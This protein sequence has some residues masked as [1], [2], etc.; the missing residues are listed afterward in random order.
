M[1]TTISPQVA[2]VDFHHARYVGSSL[3]FCSWPARPPVVG[4]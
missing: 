2:V 3:G 4:E 1:T